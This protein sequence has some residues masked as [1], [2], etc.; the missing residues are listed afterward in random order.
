MATVNWKRT[1][2]LPVL[3]LASVAPGTFPAAQMGYASLRDLALYLIIPSAALLL[4]IAAAN[5]RRGRGRVARIIAS[6]AMA[7]AVATLALEAVRYPGFRAGFMPGNLPELM[8]VLLLDRLA[9]G[10]SLASTLAGFGHHYWNGA[11]FGIIFAALAEIGVVRRRTLWAAGYGILIGLGFMASP[12]VKSLGVG[13]FGVDYG[14]HFAAT[15][16]AAH[17]AFGLVLGWML[18]RHGLAGGAFRNESNQA[19]PDTRMSGSEPNVPAPASPARTQA[20]PH[21]QT[22]V[23]TSPAADAPV[24]RARPGAVSSRIP[25]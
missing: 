9:Q 14:W 23:W 4:V 22:A 15:V 16:L 11:C 6:G 18:R 7:G 8:G 25:R 13:L 2:L 20:G 17:A 1:S 3:V 19:E 21:R 5:L 24:L 10:P 12:V